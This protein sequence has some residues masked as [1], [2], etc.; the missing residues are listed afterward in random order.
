VE[1]KR[2]AEFDQYARDYLKEL[3]H[4]LRDLV[5]PEGHYFI[6]L[7]SR[8]IEEVAI[9]HFDHPE[10]LRMVDVG[11]GLGLFEKFLNPNYSRI[12]AVDLSFEMLRVAQTINAFTSPQSAYIQ[13]NAY[14]LP[15]PD[16][17]AD[18]IFMSCVLHHLEKDELGTTLEELARICSPQGRIIFFEHNPYNP[19]TQLVVKTTP[20]DNN[21]RLVSYK[22]LEKSALEAGIRIESREFFLYGTR[23]IDDFIN[24]YLPGLR[25]LPLGGQYALIGRKASR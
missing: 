7:K 10:I 2:K 21:A 17:C 3:S 18:L 23:A 15:L 9:E 20:L 6:E 1:D 13:G 16:G 25:H 14:Q 11:T 19:F 24:R 12:A 4:P 8:I 5:D 22:K